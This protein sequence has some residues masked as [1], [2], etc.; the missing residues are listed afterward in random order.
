MTSRWAS[1][2]SPRQWKEGG[3]NHAAKEIACAAHIYGRTYVA[4][5]AFTKIGPHYEESPADLKPTADIA[6][7]EGINRFVLHTSTSSRPEDGQ[8]G[9][10]Y[11]AGTHFNRNVTWWKQSGPWLAYI[12]RCQHLL[13]Q[14]LFVGDVCY[15]NGDNAPNFVE[16]K[17]V[18]PALGPGYD[19]DVCNAEVLLTRMSV[20]DGRIILPD[21]MSY[22]LLVLPERKTMPVEVLR[23][24]ADLVD[25]GATV[26]G[27]RPE[28][29]P[30][31]KDY[32]QCD[33]QVKEIAAGLWG[34]V[35]G[36]SATQRSVGKGRVFYGKPLRE[37]LAED[38]VKPDFD[39]SRS[40]GAF[41]DF[42]HRTSGE[43]EIYFVANRSSR[44]EA[45]DCTFRVVGKQPELW[46]PMTGGMQ[47]AAA[48]RQVQRTN[49]AAVGICAPRLAVR[50][51]S[52]A[53]P[54]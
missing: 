49:H 38:G 30:G 45:L 18:D 52:Q 33:A 2:G 13:Q 17:H 48:F 4:A 21:G 43:A 41:I 36:K 50:P 29:D 51:V 10:E 37:I 34:E 44:P 6:F 14:G 22:R 42:I 25:A 35:D 47:E 39:Y 24:I 28:R 40:N 1:S 8:P 11:F 27:P 19:Y 15:Y 23:K 20:R 46:D 26:V 7:C 5:E 3:Q 9:Y 54:G 31:L 12:A 53:D 16:V 32:P